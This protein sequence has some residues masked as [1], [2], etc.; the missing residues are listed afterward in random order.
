MHT[1]TKKKSSL[2]PPFAELA[3]RI[4]KHIHTYVCTYVCM[5]I[6]IYI[7]IYT[8]TYICICIYIEIRIHIY[9][10]I[11]KEIGTHLLIFAVQGGE[12]S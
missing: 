12:D 8:Y 5:Y 7:Y 4:F 3:C 2:I 1:Q 11:H 10:Y 6:Y 9:M